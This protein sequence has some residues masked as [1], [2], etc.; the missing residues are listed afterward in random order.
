MSA[1][2][3][4]DFRCS[5]PPDSWGDARAL[6]EPVL[7]DAGFLPEFDGERVTQWR[8]EGG[9]VKVE[10]LNRVRVLS[11][12]GRALAALRAM[13]LLAGFLSSVAAV[14]HRVTGLHAT[15]DVKTPTPPELLRLRGLAESPAGLRAGRKR[16][17]ARSLLLFLRPLDDG[18]STGTVYCGSKSAEIRPVVYDKREERLSRGLPDIGHDLTRYELRLRN[19]GASLRDVFDPTAIFWHYMAPD[20]LPAPEGVPAWSAHGEGFALVRPSPALPAARLL[21]AVE[22]SSDFAA[23]CRMAA[24]FPAGES[25][26]CALVRRAVSAASAGD[27]VQGPAPALTPSSA[28]LGAIV[29]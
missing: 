25:Y 8:N 4:D 24:S 1:V 12:S 5:V 29:H 15:L 16:I 13:K 19:V 11:A 20:F 26:L 10:M 2:F 18:R 7:A 27:G 3:C 23:L 28:E 6:L 17:P 21:R 14:P 22:G 9:T